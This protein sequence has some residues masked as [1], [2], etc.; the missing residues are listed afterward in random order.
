MSNLENARR[1]KYQNFSRW[2]HLNETLNWSTPPPL[3]LSALTTLDLFRSPPPYSNHWNRRSIRFWPIASPIGEEAWLGCLDWFFCPDP[4]RRAEMNC[5]TC[6]LKE[7]VRYRSYA[8]PRFHHGSLLAFSSLILTNSFSFFFWLFGP[9]ELEPTEI[10]DVLRCECSDLSFS[11][12]LS[13]LYLR[14]KGSF[15]TSTNCSLLT[16]HGN[17]NV[18]YSFTCF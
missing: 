6:Q 12:P 5:E 18:L 3:P 1:I 4:Q 8:L 13:S 9:Q 10:R 7:L 11:H 14:W 15:I 16:R 2:T 17:P